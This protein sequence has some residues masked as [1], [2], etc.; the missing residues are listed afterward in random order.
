MRSYMSLSDE[1]QYM[2]NASIDSIY[3]TI[4]VGEMT[5][6]WCKYNREEMKIVANEESNILSD[7]SVMIWQ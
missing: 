5:V 6:M 3:Y 4:Y 1:S 2:T 7:G